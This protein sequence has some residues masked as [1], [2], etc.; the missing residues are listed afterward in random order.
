M[1]GYSECVCLNSHSTDCLNIEGE[2]PATIITTILSSKIALQIQHIN[3]TSHYTTTTHLVCERPLHVQLCSNDSRNTIA[4]TRHSWMIWLTGKC[5]MAQ[6]RNSALQASNLSLNLLTRVY[7]QWVKSATN[8][9]HDCSQLITCSLCKLHPECEAHIY[10][11][12][13][14]WSTTIMAGNLPPCGSQHGFLQDNRTCL[15]PTTHPHPPG[16]SSSTPL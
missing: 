3:I 7:R 14:R 13:A 10:Q 9:I 15:L 16:H 4:G 2:S 5:I 1:D 11:C 12:P 6:C 8:L